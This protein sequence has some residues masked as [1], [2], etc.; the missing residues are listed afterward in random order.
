MPRDDELE[1]LA[2]IAIDCGY[3]LHKDVGPGLLE[4][5]YEVILAKMIAE[6]GM[7]VARQVAVPIRYKGVVVDN[8]FRA[9]LIV[10]NRL[11]IELKSTERHA[12]IHAKQVITYLRLTGLRLGILMNFGLATFKGGVQRIAND[13]HSGWGKE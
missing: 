3:R 11:L 6:R 9:D 12:P 8:A 10:E 2:R 4:S 5:V 7:Q 13:Y 1:H